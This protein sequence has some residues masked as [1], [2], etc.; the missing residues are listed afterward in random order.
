MGDYA[1]DNHGPG[2]GYDDFA[3]D[4]NLY[5]DYAQRQQV[6]AGG[7]A[8]G[9]G[10]TR[11]LM[12]AGVGWVVGSKIHCGRL[13]K[14]LQ[15]KFTEDQKKLYTQYYNDVYELQKQNNELAYYVEQMQQQAR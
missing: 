14:K 7:A 12:G 11:A 4:D 13:K 15:T 10:M 3:Q 6:K 9:G 5:A 2:G 1:D 8:G